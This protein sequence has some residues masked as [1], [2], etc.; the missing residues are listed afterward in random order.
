[1]EHR[2]LSAEQAYASAER[3]A[4]L[5]NL[6]RTYGSTTDIGSAFRVYPYYI[7]SEARS[8]EAD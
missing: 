3:L 6:T 8:K 4:V 7:W 1:M 5:H 2:P